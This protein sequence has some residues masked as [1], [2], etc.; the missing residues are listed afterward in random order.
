MSQVVDENSILIIDGDPRICRL[1]DGYLT[2]SGY[3]VEFVHDGVN[4]EEKR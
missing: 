3:A 1:L 4:I 2:A